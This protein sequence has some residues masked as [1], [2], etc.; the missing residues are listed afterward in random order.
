[1]NEIARVEEEKQFPKRIGI[2]LGDMG[3]F[4]RN[5]PVLKYLVLHM[6]T[7]QKTFEFE[8]LP[9][10]FD[11]DISLQQEEL[12]FLKYFIQKFSDQAD[13]ERDPVVVKKGM[14]W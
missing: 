14:L 11:E 10:N 6:N 4:N 9:T 5:I 12:A 1:M 3:K 7:L 8:F 13:V 2:L